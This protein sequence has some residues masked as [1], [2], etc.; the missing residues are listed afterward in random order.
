MTSFDSLGLDGRILQALA[1]E[2]YTTPTPIQAQ[3]I[4]AARDGRDLL[5]IAQTGTGKT[6]AFGLPLLH[7]LANSGGRPPRGG[8]RALILSPTRELASQIADSLKAYGRHLGL[9][10][11]VVFGGVGYGPQRQALARGLDILVATPGRLQDHLDQGSARLDRVEALVL[12][13]ADQMLD[14]GF[15]PAIRRILPVLPKERQTMF[16]SATMPA[17][18]AKL[19]AEILKDPLRVEVTPVA[20]TAEKVEQKLIFVEGGGKRALL[21]EL[22][23]GQG[24]GRALVFART[25]HG[26]D[27]VVKNLAADG[28]QANAIHGNKGQ[29]QRERA[30]AEFRTG[31]APVLVATDIAARGIDVDGVTHVIQHD[32]PDTPEAYVHRIGRTARAGAAGIAIALCSP[33]EREKLWQVEKLIRQEI[34]REDRRQDVSQPMHRTA[35]RPDAVKPAGGR[36]QRRPQQGG[37]GRPQQHAPRRDAHGPKQA[38]P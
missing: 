13:E 19:S 8:C 17:E 24:V 10:V 28:I 3:S 27:K 5:G 2:G 35:G 4:P 6:A 20:T 33:D 22:L 25:K 29:S 9:S 32:M 30:L 21:A 16:F 31:K 14:K 12:D 7:R 37:G 38:L 36:G 34:P 1:E 18:V 15:W 26:A 11:A 23:R